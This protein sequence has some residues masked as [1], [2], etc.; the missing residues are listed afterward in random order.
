MANRIIGNQYIIDSQMGASTDLQGV[1]TASW[2]QHQM[3]VKTF[4][5][6]CANTTAE[7]ELVYK[8]DTTSTAVRL[9]AGNAPTPTA[10]G[11]VDLYVGGVNF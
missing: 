8:A 1:N 9:G 5:L 3:K 6:W 11:L 2:L 4:A 7:I 10:G